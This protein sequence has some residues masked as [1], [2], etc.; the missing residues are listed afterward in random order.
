MGYDVWDKIKTAFGIGIGGSMSTVGVVTTNESSVEFGSDGLGAQFDTSSLTTGES[1][2]AVPGLVDGLTSAPSAAGGPIAGTT[3]VGGAA[4]IAGSITSASPETSSIDEIG[5]GNINGNPFRVWEDSSGGINVDMNTVPYSRVEKRAQQ[6]YDVLHGR[7]V[8]QYKFPA[9]IVES[10]D[11]LKAFEDVFGE[12]PS[13]GKL[14]ETLS[15]L[16]IALE[17]Q[18]INEKNS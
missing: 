17:R 9:V 15:V 1:S 11:A 4:G 16:E 12:N 3:V 5:H 14:A 18:Q 8:A 10:E 7:Q 2:G 13:S 6:A